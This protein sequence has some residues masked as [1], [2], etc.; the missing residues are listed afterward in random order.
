MKEVQELKDQQETKG[1]RYDHFNDNIF[2]A[3]EVTLSGCFL[4]GDRGPPGTIGEPGKTGSPGDP[5]PTGG[6]GP[7]GPP[8]PDVSYS[9]PAFHN[10][11]EVTKSS[12]ESTYRET[13]D[14]L[15][16]LDLQ[17]QVVQQASKAQ[18]VLMEHLGLRERREKRGRKENKVFRVQLDNRSK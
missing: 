9:L 18:L 5:G 11:T 7:R 3:T 16:Q 10:A 8:G 12:L 6:K 2:D 13:K 1:L 17:D 15:D 14:R 4:Q